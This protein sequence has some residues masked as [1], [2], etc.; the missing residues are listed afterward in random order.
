MAAGAVTLAASPDLVLW[1]TRSTVHRSRDFGIAAVRQLVFGSI[2]DNIAVRDVTVKVVVSRLV[3]GTI[4]DICGICQWWRL[5]DVRSL[6]DEPVT[7]GA[8]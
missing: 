1:P 6:G 8:L 3:F 5:L 4:D 2:S 7:T